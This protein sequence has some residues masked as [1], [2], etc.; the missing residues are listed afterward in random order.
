[1]R[2]EDDARVSPG[3]VSARIELCKESQTAVTAVPDGKPPSAATAPGED[4]RSRG[5]SYFEPV[6]QDCVASIEKSICEED[7]D[8]PQQQAMAQNLATRETDRQ[9]IEH[10]AQDGFAG[11][12]QMIFETELAGYGYPV[13]MAW[14]RTGEIMKRVAEAGRPLSIPD[15]GPG[16]SR[17][18]RSELSVETVARALVFFRNKV[19]VPGRWDPA[20]G[21]TVKTYFIGACLGQFP[22]VYR[23]WAGERRRW[24]NTFVVALDDP[25]D[26]A[27]MAQVPSK[28]D[29]AYT[30]QTNHQVA[31]AMAE[32][33]DKDPILHQY[34]QLRLQGYPAAEAA[35]QAGLSARAAEGRWY[36]F[37]KGFRRGRT[38]GG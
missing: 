25:D 30:A 10:L 23:R 12:D 14:T 20:R 26:P 9:L 16:W 38:E 33:A 22:N 29:P 3:G 34:A 11:P 31:Q 6:S 35:R 15:T 27:G 4:A 24:Q 5:A 37:R 7:Y 2:A 28:D 17:D 19:L 18:D 13:M 1:M 32:L 21:T 36:R 8:G